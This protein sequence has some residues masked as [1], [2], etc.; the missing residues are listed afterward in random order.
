MPIEVLAAQDAVLWWVQRPEAP[1]QIGGL[2][3][4]EGA[5]LRH[6]DGT[7][8]IA[9]L[10]AHVDAVLAGVPRFR[11]RVLRLPLGQV[12]AWVDDEGFD[13]ARHVLLDAVPSPG[14]DA[15]LRV[16]V[17]RILEAPIDPAHPLWEVWVLDGLAGDRVAVVVKASHV[18]ADGM[19]LVDLA[20]RLLDLEPGVPPPSGGVAWRPVPVP[21]TPALVA[22]EVGARV[23]QVAGG[24]RQVGALLVDPQTWTGMAA[25][26][27]GAA[28][29]VATRAG[30]PGS[31]ASLTGTRP[32][33]TGV[34]GRRRDVVW[35]RLALADVRRVAHARSVT[36]NDVVLA[37]AADALTGYLAAQRRD[38]PVRHPRVIVPVSTHGAVAGDEVGNRFAVALTDLPIGPEDP[39]ARLE[40]IHAALAERKAAAG[41]SLGGRVFSLA[42]LLPPV[43]LRVAGHVILDHQ[44]VADLAVSDLPG[45]RTP[46]YLLGARMVE[47]YPL[48]TGTGNLA[49]IVGVL[50]YE[51]ALGVCITVDPDVVADPEVLLA[52]FA[53]SLDVLLDAVDVAGPEG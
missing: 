43:V 38:A 29:A 20:T 47:V 6:P 4:F 35:A 17:A 16:R 41:G 31:R 48:I 30:R 26:A 44:P 36:I 8:R 15:E 5:A 13:V 33:L 23:G 3:L 37:L 39:L 45:P 27:V 7:L 28:S 32:P 24:L 42:G 12:V 10:R 49:T 22:A 19:A 21:G 14:G 18:L 34:V 52:G 25:S 9:D 46:L 1:L 2:A 51:D 11:Q 40:R 53:R 50:S